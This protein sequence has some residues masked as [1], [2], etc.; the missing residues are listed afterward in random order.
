M[1]TEEMK[2]SNNNAFNNALDY[3]SSVLMSLRM[4]LSQP[5]ALKLKSYPL[6]TFAAR[7]FEAKIISLEN[8]IQNEEISNMGGKV[9]TPFLNS[10]AASD[11][12]RGIHEIW[13]LYF[14]H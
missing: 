4:F 13:P 12:S 8:E 5:G 3:E 14:T 1:S 11:F 2:R 9:D 10:I 7:R 6:K